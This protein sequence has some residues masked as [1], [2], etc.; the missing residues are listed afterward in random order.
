[1]HQRETC[2][3]R[4]LYLPGAVLSPSLRKKVFFY[5]WFKFPLIHVH[6][7]A[8]SLQK[9][10]L[11]IALRPEMGKRNIQAKEINCFGCA[12]FDFRFFTLDEEKVKSLHFFSA[13]LSQRF[14]AFYIQRI[15]V[16][17]ISVALLSYIVTTTFCLTKIYL[18]LRPSQQ[19]QEQD[20][21]H[22]GQRKDCPQHCGYKLHYW[23]VISH[24]V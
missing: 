8:H 18:T 22:Q 1:M 9:I 21:D 12:S 14:V 7:Y 24:L 17:I 4:N 3:N 5:V 19:A 10:K 13:F 11:G 23:S 6:M 2:I 16:G 15:A 20:Q